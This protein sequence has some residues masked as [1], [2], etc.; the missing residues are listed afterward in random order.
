M[1]GHAVLVTG[2]ASGIGQATAIALA[3][4]GS[5]VAVGTYEDDAHDAHE[6]VE[7]IKAAGGEAILVAADVRNAAMMDEACR[8]IVARFGRLDGAVANAGWLQR[9]PLHSMTDELW[10]SVID[11]DLTGV[12]RTVRAAAAHL[13]S[14]GAMVCVSSIAGGT[15]GWTGHTPYTAAKAG[16]LGFVRTAAL[17]LAPRGIRINTVQ[18]GMIES[19]QSLDPV[20]SAGIEGLERSRAIVPLGRV[21]TPADIADVI[22]FLLSSAARYI[23]GQS[24]TVDGGVT[25]A[26]PT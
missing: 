9:A 2:A 23:T 26:W 10:H 21:G 14:N 1:T 19:P 12:M 7:I 15:L 22:A 18:P 16:V 24:I 6:T 17:E 20:N 8:T 3:A 11:V 5:S 25:A 13:R 4:A